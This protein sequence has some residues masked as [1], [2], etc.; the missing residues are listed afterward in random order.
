M[1]VPQVTE[2]APQ[3]L[4]VGSRLLIRFG[5]CCPDLAERI[6]TAVGTEP[7]RAVLALGNAHWILQ[8]APNGGVT[9]LGILS[10][11]W[12]VC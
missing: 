12:L 3:R 1:A 2:T 9:I 8:P 4:N 11:D 5:L 10:E 6:I 7:E